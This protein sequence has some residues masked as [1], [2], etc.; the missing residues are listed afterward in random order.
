MTPEALT[1]EQVV[2]SGAAIEAMQEPNGTIPWTTGQHSDVWNHVE[3]TMALLVAGRLD[4]VERAWSWVRR[5][6]RHDG[7]FAMK[8]VA[9]EVEDA[10]G[11]TNM[12][13]YV[14]A[15]VWHHWLVRG[16]HG[17][18]R[19][20]WP[21]VRR[22]LDFVC[23]MQLP[24]GGVAWSQE[25]SA[26]GP[27]AVNGGALLAGSSSIHH[28]LRAGLSLA[29]LVGDPQPDWELAAGRLGHALRE[30]RD[31]FMDKSTFSM[32]WYYPV[33]GGAVRGPAATDLIRSRWAD[34]V[35]PGLGVRC[36][37]TNPWVTGAE[38][39][40]LVMALEA[41]GD[42]DRALGLFADMQHLRDP[43]GGYW[44]GYVY[45]DDANWPAEHTT[46]TAAAVL[47]AHDALTDTTPGADLVRGTRLVADPEPL[48]LECGCAS[49]DAIAGRS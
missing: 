28:S 11:E 44:T 48:A 19:S 5:G 13:A 38:T 40:E 21:T 24:F 42:R 8:Y 37:D 31:D 34:F 23:G 39:C 35:V 45:P 47:L 18:V 4:A 26:S 17:F 12:T 41:M 43:G 16:D 3:S 25:W 10:S 46:Y 36:V 2:R 6:Q 30:H 33:L 27:S 14:A 32:D 20:L 22:A 29:E 7:S 49:A 15:G 9:G 1:H